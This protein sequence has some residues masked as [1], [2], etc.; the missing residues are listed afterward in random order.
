MDDLNCN[1]GVNGILV[2][3]PL[4]EHIDSE[5][6]LT[7]IDPGKDVDGFHPFNMGKLMTGNSLLVPCTPMGIIHLLEESGSINFRC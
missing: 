5:K 7:A 6:V 2:Q 4:P 1:P 3:L